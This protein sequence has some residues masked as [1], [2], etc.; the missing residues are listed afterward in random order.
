MY[1][2]AMAGE[3]KSICL[4]RLTSQINVFWGK[5]KLVRAMRLVHFAY[6]YKIH[7]LRLVVE[8]KSVLRS[9]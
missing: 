1:S 7:F 6:Q 4:A 3:A 9:C 2:I 8:L 5:S